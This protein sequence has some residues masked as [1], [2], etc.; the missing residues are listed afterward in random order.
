MSAGA[1][2]DIDTGSI[3]RRWTRGIVDEQPTTTGGAKPLV[4]SDGEHGGASRRCGRSFATL[5]RVG[6]RAASGIDSTRCLERHQNEVVGRRALGRRATG[7]SLTSAVHGDE[8]PL[9]RSFGEVAATFA[10]Y[11]T[12]PLEE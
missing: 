5:H 1:A 6:R 12:T 7:V 8:G 3:T 2:V 4:L 10:T 9:S 11:A